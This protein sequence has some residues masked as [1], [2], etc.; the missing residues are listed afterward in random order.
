MFA[1]YLKKLSLISLPLYLQVDFAFA[2]GVRDIC[3]FGQCVSGDAGVFGW[4]LLACWVAV[5]IWR[6]RETIAA[7]AAAAVVGYLINPILGA[8]VWFIVWIWISHKLETDE[9]RNAA[10]PFDNDK[11]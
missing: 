10:R 4:V 11:G 2:Q 8:T 3:A 5:M 7:S 6:W 1:M 9:E